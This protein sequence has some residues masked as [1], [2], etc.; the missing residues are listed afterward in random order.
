MNRS[1]VQRSSIPNA[2]VQ[3]PLEVL[4]VS[5]QYVGD[6]VVYR[7][8][9]AILPPKYRWLLDTDILGD[10]LSPEWGEFDKGIFHYVDLALGE[11]LNE[12]WQPSNGHGFYLTAIHIPCTPCLKHVIRAAPDEDEILWDD[13]FTTSPNVL[14]K[15]G[16]DA[17][18][19][20]HLDLT[21]DTDT[22]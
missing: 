17:M 9:V 16:V 21:E 15:L 2:V 12:L 14:S 18:A 19:E 4:D 7:G 5:Y 20:Y 13:L 8:K 11:T 1:S 22:L 10:E 6:S 3:Y